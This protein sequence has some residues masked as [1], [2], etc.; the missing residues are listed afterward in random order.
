MSIARTV[1]L[2]GLPLLFFSSSGLALKK[3]KKPEKEITQVLELPKDP[4]LA[5]TAQSQRLVFHVS[6]LSSKGLLSQQTRDALKALFRSARGA[7]IIRLRAFVAGSGDLRRVSA[8]V[9]EEFTE[10]RLGI[11]VLS[12]VQVGA[13]PVEG[14]QVVMESIAAEKKVVNPNG[15]A[16]ISGQ[17]STMKDPAGP[18]IAAVREAGFDAASV[19]RVTCFLSNLD[20]LGR[21]REQIAGAFPKAAANFVQLQ[22]A[23][24]E[25]LAE[26]EAVARLK[27]KPS[28]P[29]EFLKPTAGKYSQIAIV[30]PGKIALTGMQ[31]AFRFQDEDVRLAFGRLAKALE[32]VDSSLKNA[33]MTNFYPLTTATADRV[34]KIRFEFYDPAK[35]PASTMLLFEGLPSLDAAFG[36][37][38]IAVNP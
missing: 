30:A 8:I 37:D 35:P 1:L 4:P 6:P 21:A 20:G 32:G 28:R 23:S 13:L 5:L 9:S 2:L 25:D 34:R 15:I 19:L 11:P 10:R 29:V 3:K 17:P 27:T 33:A 22:R 36:V 26:C 24:L 38:V 7:N 31:L 12:T 14:T 16:L 18:L